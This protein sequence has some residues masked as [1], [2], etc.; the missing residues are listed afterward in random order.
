MLQTII[1]LVMQSSS[2]DERNHIFDPWHA[3]MHFTTNS[4]A[5]D[6]TKYY[7][8]CHFNIEIPYDDLH[9]TISEIKY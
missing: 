6:C 4:L 5:L 3:C 7:L 9:L 8:R 1:A 2:R